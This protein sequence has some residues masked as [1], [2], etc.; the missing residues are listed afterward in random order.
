MELALSRLVA[1]LLRRRAVALTVIALLFAV[2]VAGALRLRL[3]FSSTAFYGGEDQ[4]AHRLADFQRAWGADDDRLLVLIHP[5]DA[6]DG[7]LLTRERLAAVA[8]LAEDLRA[9]PQVRRVVD[10]ADF[11]LPIPGAP[12]LPATDLQTLAPALAHAP[13]ARADLL[14]RLP[15]VPT[16]LAADGSTTAIVVELGFSTDDVMRT[17]AAVAE[18]EPIFAAHDPTLAALGLERE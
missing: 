2:T 16:L 5:R 7:D 15:F 8:A 14:A 10:V 1:A 17:R 18:L 3:D 4:A 9:D 6:E 11:P 13:S 12:G